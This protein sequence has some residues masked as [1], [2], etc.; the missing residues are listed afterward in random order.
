MNIGYWLKAALTDR[1]RL[2]NSLVASSHH[3][4]RRRELAAMDLREERGRQIEFLRRYGRIEVDGLVAE[5]E[6]APWRAQFR[7]RL[8]EVQSAGDRS[9]WISPMFDCETIYL[10]VRAFQPRIVVETGALYGAFSAHILGAL[11][12]NGAGK[13]I[14]LDLPHPNPAAPPKDFLVPDHLK[15]RNRIVLGDAK[16]T[17]PVVLEE[18]GR[19]SMFLHD[20]CHTIEHMLWEYMTASRWLEPGGVIASHDVGASRFKPDP[21][22]I[23]AE[24][25]GYAYGEFYTVGVAVKPA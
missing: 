22:A 21:F 1:P 2:I 10:T 12:R 18:A 6:E 4:Q 3:R 25:A 17:L 20:S 13:L 19:I 16:R 14:S 5:L 8:D 9:A 7:A 24:G 11:D 15:G 23:F